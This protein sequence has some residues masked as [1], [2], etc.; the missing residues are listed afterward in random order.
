MRLSSHPQSLD[1]KIWEFDVWVTPSIVDIRHTPRYQQELQRILE[2]LDALTLGGHQLLDP[3]RFTPSLVERVFS[4]LDRTAPKNIG[5]AAL[6]NHASIFLASVSALLFLVTA[7]SDNNNKCQFPIFLKNSVQWTHLPKAAT[8]KPIVI[9]EEIPRVL[10]SDSY[11]KRIAGLYAASV[12]YSWSHP[13]TQPK[14]MAS[15]LLLQFANLILSD[16]PSRAQFTAF[17]AHFDLA[18]QRNEDPSLLLAPLVAFQVRGSVAASGG[19]EPEEILRSRMSQWGLIGG[20][21]FNLSDVVLD[22]EAHRRVWRLQSRAASTAAIKDKTRAYDFVLPFQTPNWT[23]RI[24]IQ[25]Q[26]YAGDAGSVSHKNVDQTKASR[27]A[28]KQWLSTEFPKSPPPRFVEFVDGA[29]YCASLNRD[30]IS[31]LC[32]EDTTGFFQLRSAPIRLRRELQEI[33]FLT[34]LEVAH[35]VLYCGEHSLQLESYLVTEGYDP[36]EITRAINDGLSSGMLFSGGNNYLSVGTT[37]RPLVQ[38]YLLLDLIARHGT[39]FLSL[40]GLAGVVLVPGYGPYYGLSLSDLDEQV[41]TQFPSVW[42]TYGFMADLQQLC[43]QGFAI[44]R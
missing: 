43:Q 16:L 37:C 22:A 17:L 30:L 13:G 7:K 3:N 40:H 34:P 14:D 18:R 27:V 4:H 31:I 6:A 35:A 41:R 42:G 21:D 36:T 20:R 1:E 5:C 23:P 15:S 38:Q 9:H 24:F 26:F 44:L 32:Y 12:F 2:V 39:N 10:D 28:A 8:N 29:G 11:M 25:A 19:H 33:G